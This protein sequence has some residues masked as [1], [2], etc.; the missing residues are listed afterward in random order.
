MGQAVRI[1]SRDPFSM[2]EQV[3]EFAPA[4]D[5]E[6]LKILRASFP[7]S[8]LTMR[9]AALAYL[10]RKDVRGKGPRDFIGASRL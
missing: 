4:S 6:A 9:V 5:A 10:T 1:S 3:M 2:A 8:P 7:D